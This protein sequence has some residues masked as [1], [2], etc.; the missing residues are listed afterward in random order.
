MWEPLCFQDLIQSQLLTHGCIAARQVLIYNVS[1]RFL[2][3]NLM[4]SCAVVNVFNKKV[5]KAKSPLPTKNIYIYIY[6]YLNGT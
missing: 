4:F 5:L 1:G 2:S 6:A 3:Y